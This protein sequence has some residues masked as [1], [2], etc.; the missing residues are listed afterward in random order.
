[1]FGF[2]WCAALNSVSRNIG[3]KVLMPLLFSCASSFI[4]ESRHCKCKGISFDQLRFLHGFTDLRC[5]SLVPAR[6][7]Y[8]L[9]LQS[10]LQLGPL[11]HHFA[12]GSCPGVA[13]AWCGATSSRVHVNI[14][15]SQR[16]QH[17]R[18]SFRDWGVK[19]RCSPRTRMQSRKTLFP[20]LPY[21]CAV[22]SVACGRRW[23]A[24]CGV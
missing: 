8:H 19:T 18:P 7:T 3:C 12:K 21:Q 11:L 15:P 6:P 24:K 1:M 20:L 22:D 23:N 10:D 2:S 13:E 17:L 14:F 9:N 4:S 5:R 16:L